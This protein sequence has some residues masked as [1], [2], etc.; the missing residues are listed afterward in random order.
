MTVEAF[1]A[2]SPATIVIGASYDIPWPYIE[3]GVIAVVIHD[4]ERV[5]L[6]PADYVV[7]PITSDADGTLTL[8]PEVAAIYEGGSL[9]I[10][11][12]TPLEQG[13]QGILG[14]RERGLERQLDATVMR[15]QELGASLQGAVRIEG[16]L[17][18][19]V[20]ATD[21]VLM[22]DS[23]GNVVPG[24]SA[25]DIADA[26]GNAAIAAAAATAAAA[27]AGGIG[28]TVDTVA[29]IA[30]VTAPGWLAEIRTRGHAAAADGGAASYRR[31]ASEPAHMFKQ[32]SADGAWWELALQGAP[33]AAQFGVG[34]GAANDQARTEAMFAFLGGQRVRFQPG[35]YNYPVPAGYDV[36]ICAGN[37]V[38]AGGNGMDADPA[39]ASDP[40]ILQYAMSG[41]STGTVIVA[42][43]PLAFPGAPTGLSPALAAAKKILPDMPAN[44]GI[45]LV[46]AAATGAVIADWT[47]PAGARYAAALAAATAALGHGTGTNIF[48]GVLYCGGEG[49]VVAGVSAATYK[50]GLTSMID[51]FRAGLGGDQRARL[52]VAQFVDGYG[53]AGGALDLVH[54]NA[55]Q[56]SRRCARPYDRLASG[57]R[58]AGSLLTAAGA[59][60]Q[61]DAMGASMLHITSTRTF[62]DFLTLPFNPRCLAMRAD[63]ANFPGQLPRNIRWEIERG[64]DPVPSTSRGFQHLIQ[65]NDEYPPEDTLPQWAAY[66]ELGQTQYMDTFWT[67]SKEWPLT[68]TTGMFQ[69]VGTPGTT[70]G[71]INSLLTYTEILGGQRG[72]GMDIVV[73]DGRRVDQP[74]GDP[75]GMIGLEIDMQP[76]KG[77]TNSNGAG[78]LVNCFRW[79]MTT[80]AISVAADEGGAWRN[81]IYL[82]H[83]QERGI[84]F[85]SAFAGQIGIDFSGGSYSDS[86][87]KLGTSQLLRFTNSN[88]YSN[89]AIE[90]DGRLKIEGDQQLRLR[91]GASE[92]SVIATFG[93]VGASNFS[94]TF[95]SAVSTAPNAAATGLALRRNTSTSRSINASG[96]INA[97]GADYAEYERLAAGVG[98]I[99]K[100]QIVGF[101]ADGLVTDRWADAISFGI[102]STAPNLVGGDDWAD[103]LPAPVEPLYPGFPVTWAEFAA[104]ADVDMARP[105]D[106]L[107]RPDPDSA[108]KR[109]AWDAAEADYA[110][111]EATALAD[112][113][114]E[115]LPPYQAAMDEW[116]LAYEARRA[117][118]DRIAYCGKVPVNV[119]GAVAGQWVVPVADGDRI[120]AALVNDADLTFAQLRIAVGRVRRVLPDGR[121]E[122]VVRA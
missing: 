3:G 25:Q 113:Q 20:P 74:E 120:G 70:G 13:W 24:P 58:A 60:A 48:R 10:S 114:A 22:W 96:T 8:T 122:I 101:N 14:Y 103:D 76:S 87:I 66:P 97:S 38:M 54:F 117:Q 23:N 11:R 45:I 84:H 92:G 62:R 61:G 30:G 68:G 16:T 86:A 65:H 6:E 34:L 39:N 85:P 83:I 94:Q 37:G 78:L 109:A 55:H 18:P 35:S 107:H 59:R 116:R 44:R 91:C 36:Y 82:T 106:H 57:F 69:A 31:A 4:G 12:Q 100:G 52:I 50:A 93:E 72:W 105:E 26:Q 53:G 32:Q 75:A 115:H 108:S 7:D 95:Y 49:D 77:S 9:I 15:V 88:G 81:G 111:A 27:W 47:A 90:G 29:A 67:V 118:V 80:A 79:P 110:E 41:P 19:T 71:F 2:A 119:V 104:A 1:E 21:A 98:P 46:P 51:G 42:A 28:P 89:I 5:V 112:W 64:N 33:V 73:S 121:A 63:G 40:R 99:A 17:D 43:Q 102:K 56:I